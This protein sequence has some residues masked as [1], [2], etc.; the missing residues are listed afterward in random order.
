MPGT[1]YLQPQLST[2]NPCDLSDT[3]LMYLAK[4][5]WESKDGTRWSD[6]SEGV[7]LEWLAD[8]I[9][10]LHTFEPFIPLITSR[11]PA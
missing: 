7:Q 9:T 3:H 2:P 11:K 4:I 6:Q 8:V 5:S 10:I 1:R